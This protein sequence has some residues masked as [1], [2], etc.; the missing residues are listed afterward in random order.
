MAVH[1]LYYSELRSVHSLLARDGIVVLNGNPICI[2]GDASAERVAPL[3]ANTGTHRAT[4]DIFSVWAAEHS[5]ERLKEAVRVGGRTLGEWTAAWRGAGSAD[6]IL[7]NL[8]ISWG[9]DLDHLGGDR[10]VRNTASY[11]PA[12]L[13]PAVDS[14]ERLGPA[15]LVEEMWSLLEPSGSGNFERFDLHVLRDVLGALARASSGSKNVSSGLDSSKVEAV[16]DELGLLSSQS[17]LLD[18]LVNEREIHL[19]DKTSEA[20]PQDVEPDDQLVASVAARAVAL[21]RLALGSV[22]TLSDRS[23]VA[24]T[25]LDFWARDL[26]SMRGIDA[27][28]APSDLWDEI[29]FALEDVDQLGFTMAAPSL[30]K[31]AAWAPIAQTLVTTERVVRWVQAV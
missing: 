6:A 2:T 26:L 9:L 17:S 25:Q 30:E 7:K 15:W 8:I 27:E 21:L 24:S 10:D 19:L 14:S 13:A 11:E 1:L 20:A 16:M 3:L 29:A 5:G 31:V 18:A 23:G 22:A 4:W 12:R 28:A